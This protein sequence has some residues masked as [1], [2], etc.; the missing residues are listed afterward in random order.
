MAGLG[1]VGSLFLLLICV[2]LIVAPLGIWNRLIKIHRDN[3][4]HAKETLAALEKLNKTLLYIANE[5]S[6]RT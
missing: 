4:R 6:K 2:L 5:V 1:I 3:E